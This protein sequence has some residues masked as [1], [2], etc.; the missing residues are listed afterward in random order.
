M[1]AVTPTD[2][3]QYMVELIN[4]ARANP[5][6]EAARLNVDLNEG[7]APGTITTDP[8]QPL[9]INMYLTDAAR[10]QAQWL[11]A[12][13]TFSHS[14]PGGNSPSDRMLASGWQTSGSTYTLENAALTL[15]LFQGDFTSLINKQHQ[16]MF[17]DSTNPDGGR[18]HRLQMLSAQTKEIGSGIAAGSFSYGG[19]TYQAFLS[20]QD[21]GAT[22]TNSFLTGVA[23]TDAVVKDQF[24]TPGEGMG[25][26]TVKAVRNS[27]GA[28]FSVQTLSSGGYS[29]ALPTGTYTVT[30]TGGSLG[31]VVTYNNV[32]ISDQNV[33]R[34]FTPAMAVVPP[35][36][37]SPDP[38]PAPQPPPPPT[39]PAFATLTSGKLSI[40]G[41]SGDDIISITLS[42]GTYT[43][44]RGGADPQTALTF[45]ASSVTSIEVTCDDGNDTF[46]AGP[47]VGP[48]YVNGGL[49]NDTITGGDFN[50][51]LTGAAG[52]DLIH[53]GGG[54]DRVS[55]GTSNDTLY[56]DDGNDRIYG[57]DGGDAMYG[58]LGVDHLWG[59]DGNDWLD[60]GSSN[61]KLYG[62]AGN[63][64]L[65]GQK[66]NDL[67][68]G[69]DGIDWSDFRAG[70]SKNALES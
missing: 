49:G 7:L 1:A 27:D 58:G 66:G 18:G 51:T 29:L 53:G 38:D 15:N 14:G 16:L 31:G 40:L 42:S 50:D 48:V 35:D 46:T 11:V 10:S 64:T 54:D 45:T 34:D 23:Y 62:E 28:T 41:T 4:R 67:L 59:G 44:T 43:V 26:V 9:A 47:G 19:G 55:G 22:G 70:D 65:Y 3:E 20:V 52:R 12:N 56:G 25:S 8:K 32:T 2:F 36:P 5:A 39:P 68:D 61:D 17:N 63:D 57:D 60:G 37:P 33:K 24:Y 13:S 30:A 21:F 69:G 6:A